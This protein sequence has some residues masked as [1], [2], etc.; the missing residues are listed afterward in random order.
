MIVAFLL[1][2]M[3]IQL[4]NLYQKN[5]AYRQKE[6]AVLAEVQQQQESKEN[7]KNYEDYTKS[8]DYVENT[9]KNKLGLVYDNEIV[10][11]EK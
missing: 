11:K 10:F 6:K 1:V 3:S 2:I 7:L 4:A 8:Q 9:A 5:E